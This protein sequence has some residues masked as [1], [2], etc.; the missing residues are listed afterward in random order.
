MA[1]QQRLQHVVRLRFSRAAASCSKS[2][3]LGVTRKLIDTVFS[4]DMA[5]VF[6]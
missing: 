6:V 2:L 5:M 3:N 4:V 1:H